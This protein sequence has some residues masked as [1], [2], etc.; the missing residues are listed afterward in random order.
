MHQS[1]YR[2]NLN[3]HAEVNLLMIQEQHIALRYNP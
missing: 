2:G 3:N 1:S